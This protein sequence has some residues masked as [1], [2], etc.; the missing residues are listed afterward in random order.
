VYEFATQDTIVTLSQWSFDK[1]RSEGWRAWLQ[2]SFRLEPTDFCVRYFLLI[3]TAPQGTDIFINDQ[4][5]AVYTV[6]DDDPP[7]ELDVTNY[8]ALEDNTIAFRVDCETVGQ[9]AGVR[10][11]AVPCDVSD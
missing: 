10:L 1:R 7:F 9:F 6:G 5:V 11:L 8:V 2:R 4:S 3:D